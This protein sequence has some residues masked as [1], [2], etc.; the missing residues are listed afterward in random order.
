M[1][2]ALALGYK[3]IPEDQKEHRDK[4]RKMLIELIDAM[5]PYITEDGMYHDVINDP[6]TFAEVT[7]PLMHVYAVYTGIATGALSIERKN[8]AD[9]VLSLV[10]SHIDENG[11][12][13][14]ACSSPAFDRLGRSSEAQAFYMLCYAARRAVASGPIMTEPSCDSSL[15]IA[16]KS[17]TS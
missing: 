5:Q 4:L 6:T 8:W 1:A 3:F 16:S 10:E 7:A 2:C 13:N 14:N 15:I 12:V 11:F 9:K 17:T